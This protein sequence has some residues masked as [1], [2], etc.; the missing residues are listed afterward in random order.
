[1]LLTHQIANYKFS[2][3]GHGDVFT[4][5]LQRRMCTCKVFDLETIYCPH[6]MAALRSQYGAHFGNKIYEYSSSYYSVKEYIIAYCEEINLVPPEDFWIVPLEILEREI[7]RPYF[8]PSKLGRRR[9]KRRSG[10]GESF[11]TRKKVSVQNM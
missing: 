9:T 2:I 1:M 5:D 3:N 7:P 10:V 8:Y 6:G 11:S 4:V